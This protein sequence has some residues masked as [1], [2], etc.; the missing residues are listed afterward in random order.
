M[1]RCRMRTDAYEATKMAASPWKAEGSATPAMNIITNARSRT[2]RNMRDCSSSALAAQTNADHAHHT[3]AS[4]SNERPTDGQVRSRLI[5]VDTCVTAKTKT[6]SQ[7][8]STG[9]V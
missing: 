7:S 2:T 1:A 6:R 5:V 4:N 3:S 8:N 9:L